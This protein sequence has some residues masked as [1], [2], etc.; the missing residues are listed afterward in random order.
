MLT[1]KTNVPSWLASIS[2]SS[3]VHFELLVEILALVQYFLSF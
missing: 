1:G 3:L 2:F